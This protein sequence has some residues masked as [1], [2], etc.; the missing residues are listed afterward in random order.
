MQDLQ[1][2]RHLLQ[3]GRLHDARLAAEQARARAPDSPHPHAVL[4]RVAEAAAHPADAMSAWLEAAVRAGPDPAPWREL[5]RV[6][7]SLGR[8]EEA[9]LALQTAVQ[10]APR[11]GPTRA[12]LAAALEARG[13]ASAAVEHLIAAASLGAGS[14]HLVE[15]GDLAWRSG[16][17]RKAVAVWQ[18]AVDRNPGDAEAWS[19][20][21]RGHHALGGREAAAGAAAQAATLDPGPARHRLHGTLSRAAG[22][23]ETAR[24]AFEAALA[25]DPDDATAMWA[26]AACVPAVCRSAAEEAEVLARYDRDLAHVRA[27]LA[28]RPDAAGWPDA[29]QTAFPAH[30]LEDGQASRQAMHGELL[31]AAATQVPTP[32]RASRGEDPRVHLVAVSAY[33]REHTVHKLFTGWLRDLDRTRFRVTALA[34]PSRE[35]AETDVVC[36]AVDHF[37]RLPRDLP[38]ALQQLAAAAPDVLLFPE[39]GMD[40]QVL[41]I[42]A[43]RL[44]PVQA[45]AWGHPITTGLPSID[46]FLSSAAMEPGGHWTHEQRVDLP[47]LG[48]H[49]TP[50]APPETPLD[51]AA[52]GLPQDRPLL[53]SVQ[54]LSKY[55]ARADRL[56]ARIAKAAPGALLVFVEDPSE[57]VTATFR[58]RMASAFAAEG[59]ALDAHVRI[60][61]RQDSIGWR[62]LL[63][64]G[65]L[66]LDSPDWSG[67]NTT[68]EA[69]ALGLPVLAFPGTT[70]RGRHALGIVREAGLPDLLSPDDEKTWVETAARIGRDPSL[71]AGLAASVRERAPRIFADRRGVPA[72]EACLLEALEKRAALPVT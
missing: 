36:A 25:F 19:K 6:A 69:L 14:H 33:F 52:L 62:S 11:H 57:A 64:V 68:L 26:L 42:A 38:G 2:A 48:L 60:L 50:C 44:A 30:Y 3:A 7:L 22:N 24:A 1:R 61:P 5:G 63:M 12:A 40:P 71:R 67:G 16:D 39:L 4:A 54:T 31:T 17:P 10:R 47:G 29:I 66:F 55:R 34:C 13:R 9:E 49:L 21:A 51:R 56:H 8:L 46:L 72:L 28:R 20:L 32:P 70:M 59:L 15:A 37:G 41:R 18:V 58:D 35:D 23:I 65:D 27:L 53:L 43:H 45:V